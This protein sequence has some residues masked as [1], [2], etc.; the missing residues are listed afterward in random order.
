MKLYKQGR[1]L[2][3]RADFEDISIAQFAKAADTSVGAFYVR[4][5]D[6]NAFLDFVISHTFVSARRGFDESLA[7]L[8]ASKK[9]VEVLADAMIAKFTAK[10][11]AGVVRMA[12]KRGCSDNERRKPFDY[13]REYVVNEVVGSMPDDVKKE[14][15][16]R[17][18]VAIQAMFGI[19]TDGITSKPYS[20]PLELSEY[21]EPITSL[22]NN[23]LGKVKLDK[24]K[25]KEPPEQP[26]VKKI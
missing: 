23:A 25:A 24:P 18:E 9:P 2:L 15:R 8:A 20:E 6:K 22:L 7:S 10:E 3:A 14:D 4:F 12:V 16:V 5:A 17:V 11:F 1:R 13:F 21:H 26:G 19:L